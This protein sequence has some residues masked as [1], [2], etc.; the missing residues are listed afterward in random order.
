MAQQHQ[1]T[2]QL[3]AQLKKD[4]W[5]SPQT[6]CSAFSEV[7]QFAAIYALTVVSRP[8]FEQAIIAYVGM[9]CCLSRRLQGHPIKSAISRATDDHLMVWFKPT[10]K[11][12]LREV[13][14]Q[15][16]KAFNPPWNI[17]GRSRGDIQ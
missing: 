2:D 4:G 1:T 17:A 13:E 9:S 11:P 6:Y 3:F 15:Y 16:I 5:K 14:A 8:Y 10:P 7:G 12:D